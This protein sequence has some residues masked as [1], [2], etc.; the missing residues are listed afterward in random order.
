VSVAGLAARVWDVTWP[1]LALAAGLAVGAGITW[2]G[3]LAGS[4]EDSPGGVGKRLA[5]GA[6]LY[7]QL[8]D[9]G[10]V[11]AERALFYQLPDRVR[12]TV[13]CAR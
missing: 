8:P 12:V 4:A 13:D 5:H 1:A 2:L 11:E 9:E 10:R 7:C 6:K 3:M